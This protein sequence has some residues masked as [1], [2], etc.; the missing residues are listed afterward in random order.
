MGYFF[1]FN[2]VSV[3]LGE[4]VSKKKKKKKIKQEFQEETIEGK[5]FQCNCYCFTVIFH[6]I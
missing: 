5:F 3:I 6:F 1:R 2:N 4:T